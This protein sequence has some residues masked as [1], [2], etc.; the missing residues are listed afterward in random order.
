MKRKPQS[1]QAQATKDCIF[2]AT[3]HILMKEGH[4]SLNTNKIAAKAGVSIG[5]LYQYFASKEDIL[6]E[7]MDHMIQQRADRIKDALSVSMLLESDEKIIAKIVDVMI[8]DEDPQNQKLE[9]Y[10]LPVLLSSYK[11]DKLIKKVKTMESMVTPILKALLIMRKPSML[12]RNLDAV[13]FV[14]VHSIRGLVMGATIF[15]RD[16]S[17]KEIRLEVTRLIRNYLRNDEK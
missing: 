6:Q 1:A 9:S 13:T 15:D 10:L 4:E 2:Q 16:L 7:L 8:F 17:K 14:L 11:K 5:S 3:A 12:K